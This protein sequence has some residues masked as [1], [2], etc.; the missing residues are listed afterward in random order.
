[1]VLSPLLRIKNNKVIKH[2]VSSCSPRCETCFPH[3]VKMMRKEVGRGVTIGIEDRKGTIRNTFKEDVEQIDELSPTKL[4]KYSAR[5]LRDREDAVRQGY[6][7][8]TGQLDPKSERR[9]KARLADILQGKTEDD[10]RS[11]G[12]QQVDELKRCP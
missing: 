12:C 7:P 10:C 1:M 8:S 5:S 9:R 6:D 2:K 11:R 3:I 4:K